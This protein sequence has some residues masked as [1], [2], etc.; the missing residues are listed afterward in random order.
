MHI[1]QAFNLESLSGL[2]NIPSVNGYVNLSFNN[3]LT[4]IDG[5]KNIDASTITELNFVQND[6]LSECNVQSVCDFIGLNN[7]MGFFNLNSTGCNTIGEVAA[8]CGFLGIDKK[9]L[10]RSIA[11]LPNPTNQKISIHGVTSGEIRITNIT[12]QLVIDEPFTQAPISI[13]HLNAGVYFAEI[14]VDG[15]K[16]IKKIIKQ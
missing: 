11:I 2:D 13:A 16:A 6:L 1:N 7:G 15:I 5:I 10:A 9:Y 14:E 4:N 3:I 8:E 12:G